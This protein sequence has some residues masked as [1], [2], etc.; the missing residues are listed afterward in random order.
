MLHLKLL[1]TD[2]QNELHAQ[3]IDIYV[4]DI[5]DFLSRN[6]IPINRFQQNI[7]NYLENRS[8]YA[9]QLQ[10]ILPELEALTETDGEIA[11]RLRQNNDDLLNKLETEYSNVKEYLIEF[12]NQHKGP[13]IKYLCEYFIA[14]LNNDFNELRKILSNRNGPNTWELFDSERFSL[15]LRYFL[16]YRIIEN[17][18]T[19]FPNDFKPIRILLKNALDN[20]LFNKISQY[21]VGQQE[22]LQKVNILRN[23]SSSD[24]NFKD[25]E[26]LETLIKNNRNRMI[27]FL[28][29]Y[30]G[31]KTTKNIDIF[32]NRE[33]D[34]TRTR[35]FIEKRIKYPVINFREQ[36][37]QLFENQYVL[38]HISQIG[39]ISYFHISARN[40]IVE[41]IKKGW[42]LYLKGCNDESLKANRRS[43]IRTM[44]KKREEAPQ[45][46]PISSE[47]GTRNTN[48]FSL[49]MLARFSTI[50]PLSISFLSAS[51]LSTVMLFKKDTNSHLQD[52][53]S[54]P[55]EASEDSVPGKQKKNR[56][57]TSTVSKN[58]HKQSP[59]KSRLSLFKEREQSIIKK[60][61]KKNIPQKIS[62]K[63]NTNNKVIKTPKKHI[64]KSAVKKIRKVKKEH[65]PKKS[66]I[67]NNQKKKQDKKLPMKESKNDIY[68][69]LNAVEKE[70]IK[71]VL[72]KRQQGLPGFNGI[73]QIS[74]S[75]KLA[76]IKSYKRRKRDFIKEFNKNND[77]PS[78]KNRGYAP[79]LEDSSVPDMDKNRGPNI[80]FGK[81]NLPDTFYITHIY[82]QF[83]SK[84]EGIEIKYPKKESQE[85]AHYPKR[86]IPEYSKYYTIFCNFRSFKKVN[87]RYEIR[88]GSTFDMVPK[89]YETVL[90][91]T[92]KNEVSPIF[93]EKNGGFF[94][95][96]S[97]PFKGNIKVLL[98]YSDQHNYMLFKHKDTMLLEVPAEFRKIRLFQ[99]VAER[100]KEI[101]NFNRKINFIKNI[102]KY[103]Y[104]YSSGNP[105]LNQYLHEIGY[106]KFIEKYY[107][108][109]CD[110]LNISAALL[111][112]MAGIPTAV[113]SGINIHDGELR[114]HSG[115]SK[116]RYY[117][118]KD[119]SFHE[120]DVSKYT[121]RASLFS[122][123]PSFAKYEFGDIQIR[124][125]LLENYIFE[126]ESLNNIEFMQVEDF[127]YPDTH[128][129]D[130]DTR[131]YFEK[132]KEKHLMIP[133]TVAKKPLF[134]SIDKYASRFNTVEHKVA[135][136]SDVYQR[137]YRHSTLTANPT[138]LVGNFKQL[139]QQFVYQL[140]KQNIPAFVTDG[141]KIDNYIWGDYFISP[142]VVYLNS[143]TTFY[144]QQTFTI[145]IF[146][147]SPYE[148][149]RQALLYFKEL[150]PEKLSRLQELERIYQKE[151]LKIFGSDKD[152]EELVKDLFY[153]H[154]E[155]MPE[156]E[157][158][159]YV[160]DIRKMQT[161]GVTARKHLRP[162][163]EN[164]LE[165]ESNNLLSLQSTK[166]IN[167][168][169]NFILN[170]QH[171]L[172]KNEIK[173]IKNKYI[174]VFIDYAKNNNLHTENY[175][176]LYY[177]TNTVSSIK[178]NWAYSSFYDMLIHD[179]HENNINTTPIDLR[180]SYFF[181]INRE[182]LN[183]ITI[184]S[185][186]E[187]Q[188]LTHFLGLTI[189]VFR[190]LHPEV[191]IP[192]KA[193]IAGSEKKWEIL[194]KLFFHEYFRI[195]FIT[196]LLS[197]DD[198]T[199]GPH[200][201]RGKFEIYTEW[202]KSDYITDRNFRF[203]AINR[204][205]ADFGINF[206]NNNQHKLSFLDMI[207]YY[208]ILS[209][210]NVEYWYVALL[211]LTWGL[212]K[213]AEKIRK[214]LL[215]KYLAEI[216]YQAVDHRLIT[217]NNLQ[218][219]QKIL[220]T[221][222]AQISDKELLGY[223]Q[224]TTF[225]DTE[226]LIFE[227]LRLFPKYA[228]EHYFSK[229]ETIVRVIFIIPGLISSI[230]SKKGYWKSRKYVKHLAKT[231]EEMNNNA[232]ID[233]R[234]VSRRSMI[235]A[236]AEKIEVTRPDLVIYDKNEA[237]KTARNIIEGMNQG[238]NYSFFRQLRE[239]IESKV[240]ASVHQS[241]VQVAG[242]DLDGEIYM[243]DYQTGDR[244]RD[245][246]F[247]ASARLG[248]PIV[249][250]QPQNREIKNIDIAIDLSTSE[251]T[252]KQIYERLLT[253]LIGLKRQDVNVRYIYIRTSGAVIPHNISKDYSDENSLI[254][255]LMLLIEAIPRDERWYSLTRTDLYEDPGLIRQDNK[256]LKDIFAE[257]PNNRKPYSIEEFI[258]N[259]NK[260]NYSLNNPIILL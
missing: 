192:F 90:L 242:K 41:S 163:L 10:N 240:N 53:N 62:K 102:Y 221:N 95:S 38:D 212:L 144:L 214:K 161:S 5:R 45:I 194:D 229:K 78:I 208:L 63:E 31:Y 117:Q 80:V 112:R 25:I 55:I 39:Q 155:D 188:F 85:K 156:V 177:S 27:S 72:R 56:G 28:K 107:V 137:L 120:F 150:T 220:D 36:I 224:D 226:K 124:Q 142:I 15:E 106:Y 223:A 65:L 157:L 153:A 71:K 218:L 133:E 37:S 47:P 147:N 40:N 211:L 180:W 251:L 171:L 73:E 111:M 217:P 191:S 3:N 12:A 61:K 205:T 169:V 149:K 199:F 136:I 239:T 139:G 29:F 18:R 13:E 2:V 26:S 215:R 9:E 166:D 202:A 182:S 121:R 176:D 193:E 24:N 213:N 246:N 196:G 17:I 249:Y 183:L 175:T 209:A 187:D 86:E 32:L 14:R 8:Y 84:G 151:R 228:P 122:D 185:A 159:K 98:E 123:D 99:M 172:T 64:E 58:G 100:I 141:Y 244:Y 91:N 130:E 232:E 134:L 190:R 83:N 179:K 245:I 104:G 30:T 259:L 81:T 82:G 92:R 233:K 34:Y 89:K 145:N 167:E 50:L 108:G 88:L 4:V 198:L 216:I 170:N 59:P 43:K 197:F 235:E 20:F 7:E 70:N 23:R 230:K 148:E 219:F 203:K 247:K 132:T 204:L 75:D 19:Y 74:R 126:K 57:E 200:E 119:Q 105:Y 195:P 184:S 11:E 201:R 109:D 42:L 181:K 49:K 113:V 186:N 250:T 21:F 178:V 254:Q 138:G 237:M 118:K 243:R 77:L 258:S 51:L 238:A 158:E 125:V 67:S 252:K 131:I 48:F 46:K 103:F 260:N 115:H 96:F 60:L 154:T 143:E 94:L 54:C 140:R 33:Y 116:L 97:R 241:A 234:A 231:L 165:I 68:K 44:F 1:Y 248:K 110:G 160:R 255:Q 257:F 129:N 206:E 210:R 225:N 87:D 174:L 227:L 52:R 79:S 256:I 66:Q 69:G 127:T 162:I 222:P 76:E 253:I 173:T 236:G 135:F 114:L 189:R 152:K 101:E 6:G 168:F 128:W 207:K 93:I 146:K 22:I 16:N 35:K 164:I